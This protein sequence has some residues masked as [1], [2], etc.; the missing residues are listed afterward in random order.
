MFHHQSTS[1]LSD[2]ETYWIQTGVFRYEENAEAHTN[3]LLSDGFNPIWSKNGF[4]MIY[5][6]PYRNSDEAEDE[7]NKLKSLDYTSMKIMDSIDLQ[8]PEITYADNTSNESNGNS[9][10]SVWR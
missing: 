9:R 4:I 1:Q 10:G 7:L 3:K 5:L 8:E 6:G 2:D